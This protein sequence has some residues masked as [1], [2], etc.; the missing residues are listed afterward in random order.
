[1]RFDMEQPC[2][3]PEQFNAGWSAFPQDESPPAPPPADPDRYLVDRYRPNV[4]LHVHYLD[5]KVVPDTC[6]DSV[7]DTVKIAEV[8]VD[9]RERAGMNP[10]GSA[11]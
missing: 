3:V 5:P 4:P 7:I 2:T 10:D 11:R 6:D 1:M 9:Q 8:D